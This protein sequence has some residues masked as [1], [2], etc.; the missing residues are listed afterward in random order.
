MFA[1][2]T[3]A[4]VFKSGNISA[5]VMGVPAKI[6]RYGAG[7]M[8][9]DDFLPRWKYAKILLAITGRVNLG[10]AMIHLTN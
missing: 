9:A 5:C 7:F 1:A 10:V 6:K 3:V 4:I 2:T 8:L